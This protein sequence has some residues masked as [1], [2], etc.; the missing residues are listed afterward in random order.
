MLRN[1][2]HYDG[3]LRRDLMDAALGHLADEGPAQVSLRALSRE[4]G[5]SH[6]APAN[7]FAD[8]RALFTAI[9]VEG[10][11]LLGVAFGDAAGRLGED[12]D[13]VDVLQAGGRAYIT[14]A[15]SHR[16]HFA[17]MWRNDLLDQDDAAL[18]TSGT[19]TL[20]FLTAGVEAAQARGWA[21][22]ATPHAVA[23]TLWSAVHGFA[24]LCLQGP[25]TRK[26]DGRVDDLAEQVVD[27]VLR[28]GSGPQGT[29]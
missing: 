24:A 29:R 13:P 26:F 10:F 28:I 16:A 25:L 11:E 20:A 23:L 12:P 18:R 8:K 1:A 19:A 4:L 15:L 6:A 2:T 9:A 17:V 7:H 3:D 22:A 5:V 14:F 27:L 21:S